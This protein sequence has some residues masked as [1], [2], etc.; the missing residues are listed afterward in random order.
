MAGAAAAGDA[1]EVVGVV[2]PLE[3]R[4]SCAVQAHII[5]MQS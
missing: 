5:I 4:R 1:S 2:V 3:L